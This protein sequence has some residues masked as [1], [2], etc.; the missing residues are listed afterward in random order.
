ML[1]LLNLCA[2]ANHTPKVGPKL[3]A[4]PYIIHKWISSKPALS[5]CTHTHTIFCFV[6]HPHVWHYNGPSETLSPHL[7]SMKIYMSRCS[8]MN[9]KRMLFAK[10]RRKK[11]SN[12]LCCSLSLSVNFHT[13]IYVVCRIS[14]NFARIPS[15]WLN[16]HRAEMAN[17]WIHSFVLLQSSTFFFPQHSSYVWRMCVVCC[18][19]ARLCVWCR[20]IVQQR[21]FSRFTTFVACIWIQICI[22]Q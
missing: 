15:A 22:I 4:K 10:I 5:N 7:F 9:T 13:Y 14:Y 3:S 16:R 17:G 8:V 19:W 20:I 1:T 12:I 18:V 2:I 6:K 21:C 11:V